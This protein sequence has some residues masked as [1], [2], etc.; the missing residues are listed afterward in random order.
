MSAITPETI[1]I[2]GT[3][4]ARGNLTGARIRWAM[5][6]VLIVFSVMFGRLIWLGNIEL[7]TTI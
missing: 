2:D 5:A 6:F 4:K 7:D 3:R 1:S